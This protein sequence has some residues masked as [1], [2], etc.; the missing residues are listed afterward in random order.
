MAEEVSGNLD[1]LV[2]GDA[3]FMN[4]VKV[5]KEF[6]QAV[7]SLL[8]VREATIKN[9]KKLKNDIVE[10]FSTHSESIGSTVREGS[11]QAGFGL[12]FITFAASLGLTIAPAVLGA[13]ANTGAGARIGHKVV[14]DQ[15]LKAV[16]MGICQD[17]PKLRTIP[18]RFPPIGRRDWRRVSVPCASPGRCW[19]QNR[20]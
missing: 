6:H 5:A 19:C 14:A 16:Q 2:K 12:S 11:M 4:S 20:R 18:W 7:I 1:R 13:E 15:S 17:G 8:A 9:L 10:S 3:D